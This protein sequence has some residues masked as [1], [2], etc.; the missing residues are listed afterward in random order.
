MAASF[1]SEKGMFV[2]TRFA[3]R[4]P[5]RL[6]IGDAFGPFSSPQSVTLSLSKGEGSRHP[7]PV[8]G[9]TGQE[10]ALERQACDAV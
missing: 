8:E 3:E 2:S 9:R 7:E 10:S 1:E 5:I 6:A 4:S